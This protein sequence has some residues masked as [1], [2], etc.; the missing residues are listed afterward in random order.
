M[1][2]SKVAF[3]LL[4]SLLLSLPSHSKDGILASSGEISVSEQDIIL[5]LAPVPKDKRTSIV[6]NPKLMSQIIERVL[7][8]RIL[9]SRAEASEEPVSMSEDS[10]IRDARLAD[11]YMNKAVGSPPDFSRFAAE[12]YASDPEQ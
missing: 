6:S 11:V 7:F 4:T 2:W 5:A 9:A 1:S 10:L 3:C 8:N 12:R